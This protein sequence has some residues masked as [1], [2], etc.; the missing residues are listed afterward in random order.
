M[1]RS[2]LRLAC[3]AL[4]IFLAACATP[5]KHKELSADFWTK[6]DVP[7]GVTLWKVQPAKATKLGP[8]GLLDVAINESVANTFGKR[9]AEADLSRINAIPNNL[10]KR[11]SSRGFVVKTL[12]N[13]EDD[14]SLPDFSDKPK[15]S[16]YAEKDYRGYKSQG[17]ERLLVIRVSEVGTRRS[18][19][20]FIPLGAPI[21]TMVIRGQLIDVNTN[22]I[23]WD[24]QIANTNVIKEPWDQEPGFE[25]LMVAVNTTVTDGSAKFE[26]SFFAVSK[27][28]SVDTAQVART[29]A[30]KT[31]ADSKAQT[32]VKTSAQPTTT[33][34]SAGTSTQAS[35]KASAPGAP[36]AE[37]KTVSSA[38]TGTLAQTA[39][40]PAPL[41]GGSVAQSNAPT[42]TLAPAPSPAPSPVPSPVPSPAPSPAAA[43]APA[44]PM[45]AS[46]SS[47]QDSHLITVQSN[48]A[49]PSG[50]PTASPDTEVTTQRGTVA[51]SQTVQ[52]Y[53]PM[54]PKETSVAS[55]QP[56]S[57][58][59]EL[60]YGTSSL[61]VE[62]LGKNLGCVSDKG[63]FLTSTPGPIETYQMACQDGR[64]LIG[65]CELRQCNITN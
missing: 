59:S 35:A 12:E 26:R 57:S 14:K 38:S 24:N 30:E 1:K 65:R 15:G 25:N 6:R 53:Q 49:K 62:K 46:N 40:L 54:A 58:S 10:E 5:Y 22:E 60:T 39:S 13:I 41:T 7:M 27:T 16:G 48:L 4:V 18:Y 36:K 19:Y 56:V 44:A 33:G 11:L 52:V 31:S 2:V 21:A 51:A 9:L 23:L 45:I 61:T 20:G 63:A 28:D 8:Q 42:S 34:S 64:N 50:T 37:V 43:P 29:D 3:A 55:P 32:L 47:V 17:I